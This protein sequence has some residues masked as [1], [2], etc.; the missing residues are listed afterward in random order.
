MF[1]EES[2][3]LRPQE[4]CHPSVNIASVCLKVQACPLSFRIGFFYCRESGNCQQCPVNR[5]CP[6]FDVD[7]SDVRLFVHDLASY[8]MY[9][10]KRLRTK[11]DVV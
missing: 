2:D 10:A 4:G 8:M 11:E 6:H 7:R 1:V 5:P 9:A 3:D